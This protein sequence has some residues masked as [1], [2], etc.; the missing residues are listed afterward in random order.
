MGSSLWLQCCQ[1]GKRFEVLGETAE[2]NRAFYAVQPQHKPGLEGGVCDECWNR[3]AEAQ[4]RP[5]PRR[6]KAPKYS[7]RALLL[8]VA[9]IPPLVYWGYRYQDARS[10]EDHFARTWRMVRA[11]QAEYDDFFV[12]ADELCRAQLAVPFVNRALVCDEHCDRLASERT[13][14]AILLS[15]GYDYNLWPPMN[16]RYTKAIQQL[17]EVAGA[18]HAKLTVLR[19]Q[20]QLPQGLKDDGWGYDVRAILE[21]SPANDNYVSI[22]VGQPFE[23]AQ[24]VAQTAGYELHDLS[25]LAMAGSPDGFYINLPNEQGL[26]VDRD[27]KSGTVAAIALVE[28]WPGPK[29]TQVFHRVQKMAVPNAPVSQAPIPR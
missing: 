1:C 15:G 2:A 12:A 19:H 22:H 8:A 25:Q 27:A 3:R 13:R 29:G 9:V 24:S 28:N 16:A 7:L 26:L 18:K 4:S 23:E 21:D 10:A 14:L 17:R 11:E 20:I 6:W 5:A